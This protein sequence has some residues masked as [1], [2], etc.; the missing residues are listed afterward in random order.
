MTIEIIERAPRHH[1]V[2]VPIEKP[3]LGG[4][5][6]IDVVRASG[7]VEDRIHAPNLIVDAGIKQLGDI[8]TNNEVTDLD[9]SFIEP[10][11]GTATPLITDTDIN[12]PLDPADRLAATAQTRSSTTPFE[13]VISAFITS[14]KYTR[15]Q[16]IT[17]LAVYFA[18][19]PSGT[20]FARGKLDTPIILNSSD[21]ATISYGIL[22]R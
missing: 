14:I 13:V 17:E 19:D 11:E 16:T 2:K 5:F 7:K 9:L 18:D 21:T 12:D 20:M 15:P 4:E 22:F 1:I 3:R 10:G 6:W 8:L